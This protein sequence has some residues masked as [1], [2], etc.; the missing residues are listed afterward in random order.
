MNV[1][2]I[3]PAFPY[4]GGIADTN[5]SLCRSFNK[6]GHQCELVTFTM[7]YPN[8]LFPGTNQYSEDEVPKD[9]QIKRK[10]N[11]LNPISWLRAAH[12]INKKSPD[13]VILRYWIPFMAPALG[14]IAKL[15]NGRTKVLAMC[16]NVIPHEK[17]LG[18]QALTNYLMSKCEGFITLSSHVK[19]ELKAFTNKDI[20]SLF[21]PINTD[22]GAVISRE[23]A[24]EKL[25]LEEN[26]NYILFFGLV[27]AYK[28]LDILLSALSEVIKKDRSIK[29]IIAGE[30]YEDR[31][32][33]DQLIITLGLIEN[34]IIHDHFIPSAEIPFYFCAADI[35]AQTY[36]TASQSGVT[37][38][39]YH[40]NL[41]LLVSDV[42]GLTE[43]VPHNR[44]GYV[45]PL[46]PQKISENLLDYF[47][48][49]KKEEFVSNLKHDKEK[50]TWSALV[51][52][53]ISKFAGK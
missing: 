27:R 7:Q 39:A 49:S 25:S 42:G 28:G 40:F 11:S 17:R 44:V 53:V 30:F 52:R 36:H 2:I 41:P 29:L 1:I 5:H 13:L 21:H 15:I 35:L 32:K 9:L 18:D 3:G 46:D 26:G 14:S 22:L 45:S 6:L 23:E 38:I 31:E 19:D 48:S 43:M 34:V 16:D 33:Y 12:Y 51:N 4:R 47:S 10:V 37:Q 50:Y 8:F 24:R 20:L